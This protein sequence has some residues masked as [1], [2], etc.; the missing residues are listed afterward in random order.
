[1]HD[2]LVLGAILASKDATFPIPV[3]FAVATDSVG[4]GLVRSLARPGGGRD[5]SGRGITPAMQCL[6]KT[7]ATAIVRVGWTAPKVPLTEDVV[8]RPD[9]P[10]P[11]V[12]GKRALRI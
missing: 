3:V 1:M 6:A 8:V 9:L 11:V 5:A 4:S 7:I 10:P 2:R 12:F